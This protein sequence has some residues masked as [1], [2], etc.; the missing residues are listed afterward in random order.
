[1]KYEEALSLLKKN[2]QEH[3]LAHWKKLSASSR[4]ALLEQ[5]EAI[6]FKA[7]KRCQNVLSGKETVNAKKGK[8]IAPK[9]AELKGAARNKAWAYCSL[10]EVRVPVL[11]LTVLR[12]LI[13]SVRLQALRFLHSTHARFWLF[14]SV[15]LHPF[16][17]M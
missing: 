10:P 5:I 11:G 14:Q 7:V 3:I 4:K 15:M 12:V 13:P 2:S 1:M 17:F 6:D 8:P 9:V 16:L